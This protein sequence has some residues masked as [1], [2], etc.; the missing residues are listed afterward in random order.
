MVYYSEQADYD[1]DDILQGLL[2]WKKIDLSREFCLSYVSDIIDV[3]DQLE[4]RTYH[5]NTVYETH[6]RYGRKVYA[7][8]RNRETTWYIIYNIDLL[9]NI[10]IN[11][12]ISNHLTII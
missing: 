1:L 8:S 3:C 12:I 11:K 9:G 6:K 10:F 2:T 5:S 4:T 7:Y